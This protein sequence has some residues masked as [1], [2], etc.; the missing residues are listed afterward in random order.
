MSQR[1]VAIAVDRQVSLEAR[2]D[3]P[4]QAGGAALILHP[5]PLFGGSMDNNVVQALA[6]ACAEAGWA[7][8][9]I[10]FRGVG[11]STGHHDQG[12]GEQDDVLAAAAWL[13]GEVPGPLVLMGYSFGSL[14]GAKAAA[15]VA[16]L[17]GGLWVS[18]PYTLG[19]LPPWPVNSGPLLVITGD[20]DEY[21]NLPRLQAYIQAM[22]AL[23]T[24]NL[25]QGGDHF[26]WE[27]LS[28]LKRQ[29]VD[30]LAALNG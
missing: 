8:L 25:H 20:N 6:G 1:R 5:H 9:R 28:A 19:D 21:G 30:F 2:L 18:P 10:N 23:G 27:G 22:G 12:L 7:S 13:A 14:M 4:A 15:R 26:W 17:A 24:L 16:G 11:R 29:A 3:L